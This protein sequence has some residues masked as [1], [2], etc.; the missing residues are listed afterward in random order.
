MSDFDVGL[1]FRAR[2]KAWVRSFEVNMRRNVA[3]EQETRVG[4]AL[5]NVKLDVKWAGVRA[6]KCPSLP[7]NGALLGNCRKANWKGTGRMSQS[8]LY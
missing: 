8:K 3:G 4:I 6:S 2:T 7:L 1:L 5:K